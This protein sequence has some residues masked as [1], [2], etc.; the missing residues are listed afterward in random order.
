MAAK[1]VRRKEKRAEAEAAERKAKAAPKKAAKTTAKKEPPKRKSRAK[2]AKE[3]RL[4]AFWGVFNQSLKR[5]A[6]YE[7][8]E[9]KEADKRAKE[10]TASGKSP[11]FVQPVKEA[12]QE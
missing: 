12:V 4:K 1:V 9:K 11:H 2:G 6:L 5:I 3:V 7:Y 10:L 8:S